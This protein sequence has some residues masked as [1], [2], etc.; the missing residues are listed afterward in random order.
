VNPDIL[1]PG[2][3]ELT[4]LVDFPLGE[5]KL[6]QGV[7]QLH[8][9][10]KQ[11]TFVFRISSHGDLARAQQLTSEYQLD[12]ISF[13]P[14]YTG[15]NL[16]FFERNVFVDREHILAQGPTIEEIL[17]K[18]KVNPGQYGRMTITA[19]GDVYANLNLPSAG[20]IKQ[21]DLREILLRGLN[22]PGSALNEAWFKSR[23]RVA[24]C[25]DCHYNL[26]CPSLNNYGYSMGRHDAC[27]IK[28]T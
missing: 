9:Y 12:N 23:D 15:E 14:F 13:V 1:T 17:L 22:D 8:A 7:E 18:G 2:N 3:R 11:T 20:N 24:P 5:K 25:S 10:K 26:L 21:E 27:R 16:S 19:R 6:A 28:S 4:L